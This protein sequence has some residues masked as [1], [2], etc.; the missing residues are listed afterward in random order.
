[1]H[2]MNNFDGN[3]TDA[4]GGNKSRELLQAPMLFAI[5][6]DAH[7]ECVA[8]VFLFYKTQFMSDWDRNLYM[9]SDIVV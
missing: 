2:I 6:I 5:L 1:M 3:Y 4:Y 7:F 9:Y 8:C